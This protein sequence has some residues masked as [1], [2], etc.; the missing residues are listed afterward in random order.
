MYGARLTR[1]FGESAPEAWA[2]AIRSLTSYQ[3]QRGLK[4]LADSGSGSVPML[5]QFV[6]ACKTIGND[7]GPAAPIENALPAPKVNYVVAFA[8]RCLL[9]FLET[10]NPVSEA[11]LKK[12]LTEKKHITD[13]HRRAGFEEGE[14]AAKIVREQLFAAFEKHFEAMPQNEL[15]RHIEHF[16]RTGFAADWMTS[17]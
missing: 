1:D 17:L 13:A 4:R 12:M 15:T 3:I 7:D 14:D 8:N 10:K 16:K 6:R 9:N 2:S 5:P 11:A